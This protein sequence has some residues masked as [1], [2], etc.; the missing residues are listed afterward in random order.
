[1]V[2]CSR[3]LGALGR[4]CRYTQPLSVNSCHWSWSENFF[5]NFTPTRHTPSRT[6]NKRTFV[7]QFSFRPSVW[8]WTCSIP[9]TEINHNCVFFHFSSNDNFKGPLKPYICFVC[10]SPSPQGIQ[11]LTCACA[12]FEYIRMN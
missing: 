9:K 1:M 3:V 10:P 6:A 12:A 5:R 2:A 11:Q 8:P 4:A 7:V